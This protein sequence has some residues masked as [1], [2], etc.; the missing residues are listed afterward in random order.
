MP[1]LILKEE[2]HDIQEPK[3]VEK[4][5]ETNTKKTKNTPTEVRGAEKPTDT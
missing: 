3:G 5:A 1:H 2:L 4:I